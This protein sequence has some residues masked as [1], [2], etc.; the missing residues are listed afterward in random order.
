MYYYFEEPAGR[1]RTI[2]GATGVPCNEADYY[3][4][5]GEQTHGKTCD[6]NYHFA[7]MYRDGETANDYTQFRMYESN[8]GRWMT[9]DPLGGD[10]LNP[11]SLN[12]YAY[13]LNNPTN[14]I[15]PLGSDSKW[16][17]PGWNPWGT[18]AG[19]TNSLGYP[20]TCSLDGIV[21]SC[22]DI[23]NM[24]EA[25][26][27]D[28]YPGNVCSSWV[29]NDKDQI[30]YKQFQPTIQNPG[31]WSDATPWITDPALPINQITAAWQLACEHSTVG[32]TNGM[33]VS[34]RESGGTY[35]VTVP[36]SI[37]NVGFPETLPDPFTIEHPSWSY[38]TWSPINAGHVVPLLGYVEGHYDAFNP[39]FLFPFHMVEWVAGRLTANQNST[40][41]CSVIGGCH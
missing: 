38:Y 2:T 6:Q 30:S 13:V 21:G 19:Q 25:G 32:C 18:W 35:N 4:F 15:D 7:G 1:T 12:R 28:P 14:L 27:A 37:P 3:L 9:P 36:G 10:I 16:P 24:I 29:T 11:Q 34:V 8:L 33:T 17:E 41:T 40:A 20:I 22:W 39:W 23:N 26:V 31:N 5:G